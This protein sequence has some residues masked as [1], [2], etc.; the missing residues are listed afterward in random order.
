MDQTDTEHRDALWLVRHENNSCAA[1]QTL[2]RTN[3]PHP[4]LDD[5]RRPLPTQGEAIPK[6]GQEKDGVIAL[7]QLL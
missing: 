5:E 4:P 7:E 1:R 6:R 3:V 2:R